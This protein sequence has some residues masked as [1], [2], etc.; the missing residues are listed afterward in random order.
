MELET[1]YRIKKET[2]DHNVKLLI[3]HSHRPSLKGVEDSLSV[4]LTEYG[5]KEA[6]L[7]G[8]YLPWALGSVSAS[9]SQRCVQT[10]ENIL[11]GALAEN[12]GISE[13]DMLTSTAINDS[14]SAAC[15]L[16]NEGNFR[17]VAYKLM[18]REE[19]LGFATIETVAENLL[20]YMF[21]KGNMPNV[22]DLYCTHD[23]NI[24]LLLAYLIPSIDSKE[25]LMQNWPE[26]LEGVYL[27]GARDKFCFSWRGVTRCYHKP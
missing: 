12:I 25:V 3:R 16:C 24:I 11:K 27:W 20:D 15:T 2:L 23:F 5:I 17:S 14:N 10:A 26:P 22:L 1:L 13:T 4:G 7:Y 18:I 8:E 21:S 9:H 6:F 19:L